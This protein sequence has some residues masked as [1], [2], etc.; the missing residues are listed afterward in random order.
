MVN[1]SIA[2]SGLA[3]VINLNRYF[4]WIIILVSDR[5][6]S[7][8]GDGLRGWCIFPS[9]LRHFLSEPPEKLHGNE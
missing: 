6:A 8:C 7:S 1:V 3:F 5:R 9:L 4:F 2:N